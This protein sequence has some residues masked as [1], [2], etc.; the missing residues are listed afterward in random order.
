MTERQPVPMPSSP[1][2]LLTPREHYVMDRVVCGDNDRQIG[3]LL[4]ISPQTVTHY[5]QGVCLKLGVPNRTAAA[6]WYDLRHGQP[7]TEDGRQPTHEPL[8][9]Q[10]R[11]VIELVAEGVGDPQIAAHLGVS[12]SSV[13]QYLLSVRRKLD[14][15][16]RTAAAVEYYRQ[17]RALSHMKKTGGDNEG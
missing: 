6:V 13:R 11:R 5:V 4:G 1:D 16:N 17:V 10:E 8:S 12:F 9:P 2:T 15:P 14:A 7:A 3:H